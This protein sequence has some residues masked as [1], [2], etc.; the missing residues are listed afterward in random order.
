VAVGRFGTGVAAHAGTYRR[1][2]AIR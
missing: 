1:H 2:A